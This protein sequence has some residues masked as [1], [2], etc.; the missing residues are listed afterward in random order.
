MVAIIIS[1]ASSIVSGMV[2]FLLQHY[3]KKKTKKDE[4]RDMAK[5]KENILIIK[6]IDA[7]GKLT[8]ANA[9]AIRDGKTNGEMHEAMESYNEA[10]QEMY[11]Y[12]LEQNSKK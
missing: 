8:Y 10:K 2:L 11:D 3:F 7:V 5:A 9:I 6:S 12:L 1:I 4:E